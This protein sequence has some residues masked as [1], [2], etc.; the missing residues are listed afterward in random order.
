MNIHTIKSKLKKAGIEFPKEIEINS[1][2]IEVCFDYKEEDGKG[3][4]NEEKNKEIAEKIKKVL[5]SFNY[6][7]IRQYGAVALLEN[8]TKCE[9]IAQNID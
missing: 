6:M 5:P 9:L 4:S 8:F 3:Y 7:T 2:E 1:E